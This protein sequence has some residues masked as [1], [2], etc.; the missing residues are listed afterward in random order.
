LVTCRWT[1]PR[2]L[3]LAFNPFLRRIKAIS[4]LMK[5]R[6]RY[7]KDVKESRK[8]VLPRPLSRISG[9]YFAVLLTTCFSF[10]N[11]PKHVSSTAQKASM[12]CD[13][14]RPQEVEVK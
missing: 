12:C 7:K 10:Y 5:L 13:N 11:I 3:P 2:F 14:C 8:H 9:S 4:T 6:Q 1:F